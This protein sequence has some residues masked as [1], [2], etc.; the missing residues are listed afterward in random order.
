MGA[1]K[2]PEVSNNH[3]SNEIV[4]GLQSVKRILLI[5]LRYLGDVVLSVPILPLLQKHFPDARITFLVNAETVEILQNDPH[6][7]EIWALPRSSRW[8]K[9]KLIRRL[10]ERNFDVVID[11]TD[12]DRSAFL[13]WVSGAS[14]RLGYNREGRWRGRFY[15]HVLP[16]AYGTMHMVE[17]HQQALASLGI[18]ETV[19]NPEL[20]ID[21]ERQAKEQQV[22]DSLFPSSQPVVL[23]YATARYPMKAWPLERFAVVADWLAEQRVSVGIIGSQHEILVGQQICNLTKSQPINLMGTT[24]ISQLIIFLERSC[25][26]IGNDGGPM[27][28]AAAVGCPVLALFGPSDPAVWGPRGEKVKVIYKALDCHACFYPGCSR[29]EESCM[30]QITVEEVCQAAQSM[31]PDLKGVEASKT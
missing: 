3:S 9:L 17:Y 24:N 19:K 12:G 7:D 6:V 1:V 25:L 26:L 4:E 11:L 21:S 8:E 30:R 13:S 20:F 31:L 14:V 16:S 28:M 5:K 29:G 2:D 15:S 10:R 27:H 18:T 22:F 23:L